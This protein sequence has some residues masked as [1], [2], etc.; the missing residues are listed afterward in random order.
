VRSLL[1]FLIALPLW[2]APAAA[3]PD[4]DDGPHVLWAGHTARILRVIGGRVSEQTR[5]APFDLAIPGLAEPLR[6]DGARPAVPALEMP[7]PDTVVAL[8]D[9]HGNFDGMLSLLRAHRVIDEAGRWT[10][11]AGHLVVLGDVVDKGPRVTECLWLLRSLEPQARRVGGRV[12]FVLGNHEVM[13]LGGDPSYLHPRYAALQAAAWPG[14]VPD[15]LGRDSELGRWLRSRRVLL[16]LGPWLFL[17]GGLGPAVL[18]RRAGLP[19]VAREAEKEVRQRPRK[20]FWTGAAGPL[21]YRGLIPGR[22]HADATDEEIARLLVTFGVRG[23][24]VGHSTLDHVGSTHG[25]R[26][27]GIDAGLA[28]GPGEVL[29]LDRGTPFR[30]LADG[31]RAPLVEIPSAPPR[32]WLIPGGSPM[33]LGLWWPTAIDRVR[34]PGEGVAT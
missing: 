1:G 15:L 3:P 8:S 5:K 23:V 12:H 26:V 33:R 11:G 21:W 22:D 10:L 4:L 30:G 25:G 6:L 18:A 19:E 31:G 27:I 20:E 29:I 2:L 24:V 16:K 9:V 14:G 28:T 34:T 17:H 13:A 32:S 7:L